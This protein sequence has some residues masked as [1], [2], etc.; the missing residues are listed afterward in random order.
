MATQLFTVNRLLQSHALL[1]YFVSLLAKI[2]AKLVW[3]KERAGL[4]SAGGLMDNMLGPPPLPHTL[5]NRWKHRYSISM[6]E[7]MYRK[8]T[9][10]CASFIYA[11]YARP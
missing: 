8:A 2:I 10:L 3:G 7:A 5:M 11:N 4:G 6:V 1:M 9:F